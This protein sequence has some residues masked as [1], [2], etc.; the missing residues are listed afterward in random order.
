MQSD[1]YFPALS[2][3]SVTS[4]IQIIIKNEIIVKNNLPGE[5]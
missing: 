3:L 1:S 2:T 5:M 4:N